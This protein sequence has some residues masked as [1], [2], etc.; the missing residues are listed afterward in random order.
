MLLDPSIILI[1]VWICERKLTVGCRED[2]H[3]VGPACH[4]RIKGYE[5]DRHCD[6]YCKGPSELAWGIEEP[7]Q[8][9]DRTATH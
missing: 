7:T 4:Y 6:C 9:D 5:Q 8:E 1:K 2:A 3:W